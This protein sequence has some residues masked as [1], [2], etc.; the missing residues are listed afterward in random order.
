MA[1]YIDLLSNLICVFDN[2]AYLIDTFHGTLSSN[3]RLIAIEDLFR[4][5]SSLMTIYIKYTFFYNKQR[6]TMKIPVK[7]EVGSNFKFC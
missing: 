4:R 7:K 1:I 2:R 3:Y 5:F 6:K